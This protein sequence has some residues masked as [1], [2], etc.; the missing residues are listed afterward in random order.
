MVQ[1]DIALVITVD[2]FFRVRKPT[3][4]CH[5]GPEQ[6]GLTKIRVVSTS[7]LEF[8]PSVTGLLPRSRSIGISLARLVQSRPPKAG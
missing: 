7:I 8:E 6:L 3:V 5:V 2:L 4:T 1:W